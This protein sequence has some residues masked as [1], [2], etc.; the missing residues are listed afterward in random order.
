MLCIL[1]VRAPLGNLNVYFGQ[2]IRTWEYPFTL[3]SGDPPQN[4]NLVEVM[5]NSGRSDS[6]RNLNVFSKE[7]CM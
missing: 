1:V 4:E 7:L 2:L 5:V 3:W 6:L